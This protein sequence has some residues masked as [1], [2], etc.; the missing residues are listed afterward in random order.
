MRLGRL[1]TATGKA[2]YRKRKWIAEAPNGRVKA[3]PGF[4]Q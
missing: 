4:R 1:H 2:T 3:V